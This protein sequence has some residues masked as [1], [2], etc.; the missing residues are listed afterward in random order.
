V[1]VERIVWVV[2]AL[3]IL[4]GAAGVVLLRNPVHNALSLVATLF[5][6]AMMFVLQQA[7]FLAAIQV[8][9]YG[10]AIVVLFLFVIM[11]LGVDRVEDPFPPERSVW[12]R[13]ASIILG[14]AFIVL[15]LIG[16]LATTTKVTGERS[17]KG[18]L[19]GSDINRIGEL[20]FTDYLWAFEIT[21]VLLTVA[22]IAAVVLSRRSKDQPIDLD[23][24]P[25]DEL[26][27]FDSDV[28][29]V[30]DEAADGPGDPSAGEDAMPRVVEASP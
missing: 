27:G 9:V 3:V 15:T 20:L 8:I 6:V 13:P 10:G 5:G 14:V 16:V 26:D 18:A 25:P 21:G 28:V 2:S 30:G 23:E 19:E 12:R 4:S 7:Y 22:V 24:F 1:I 29:A 17:V 11:L